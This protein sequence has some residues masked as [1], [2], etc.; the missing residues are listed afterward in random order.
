VNG[1]EN[2]HHTYLG[3]EISK[4]LGL[5]WLSFRHRNY[6]PEI[7]RFFGVDPVAG[8]Y[9]TISPYQFAHNNPIWKIELEGLEGMVLNG[10][11]VVNAPPSGQSGQNPASH[12][13]LPV[14]D[15]SS[16]SSSGNKTT[17]QLVAIEKNQMTTGYP[18]QALDDAVTAG[19]QWI[20]GKLTGSDVSTETAGNIQ[21]ATDAIIL[22][23]SKGKSGV[24]NALKSV[25]EGIEFTA[26]LSKSK[27][28]TRSGH[29]NAANKQLNEAMQKD[30]TL[31]KQ[32]EK[33]DPNVM[34]NTSR[35]VKSGNKTATRKNPKGHEWDHNTNNKNK[36]DLRSKANHQQ[37]TSKDKGGKGGWW[38]FWQ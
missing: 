35:S 1:T 13:P 30:P 32:M 14:G 33:L 15:Q 6:M 5:N 3:K 25:D 17:R 18:G 27:A 8:D 28:T 12:L 31:Q 38:K 24:K 2:N 11:D 21:M 10:I 36:I 22:V 37:K 19:I 23:T 4:E 29:R 26:D 20:A 34:E 16:G 7:G 9:V